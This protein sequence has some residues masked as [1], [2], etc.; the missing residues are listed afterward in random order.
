MRGGD[1]V[2]ESQSGDHDGQ[3]RFGGDAIRSRVADRRPVFVSHSRTDVE[4]QAFLGHVYNLPGSIYRPVF[5]SILGPVAPHAK[6]IIEHLEDAAA[7][8][9]L[10]SRDMVARSHTRA[11]VG[12]EVGVAAHRAVPVI[13]VEPIEGAP[14][15][16]PVPG[17]THYIRRAKTAEGIAKTAWADLAKESYDPVEDEP[18]DATGERAGTRFMAWLYNLSLTTRSVGGKF[19]IFVCTNGECRARYFVENSILSGVFHCPSCR[20]QT[21]TPM[22]GVQRDLEKLAEEASKAQAQRGDA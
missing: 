15:D 13:V 5:Y 20:R 2:R 8:V 18:W 22:V 1:L 14:F 10:L 19:T 9:V 11:W 7:L 3:R 17:V 12:F 4:G 21:A 6:S 16:L